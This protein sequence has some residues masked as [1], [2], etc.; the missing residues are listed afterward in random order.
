MGRKSHLKR[1]KLAE[2]RNKNRRQRRG[3]AAVARGSERSQQ[4]ALGR[5]QLDGALA[6]KRHLLERFDSFAPLRNQL[7]KISAGTNEFAGIPV[8]LPDQPMVVDPSYRFADL[9]VEMGG[10]KAAPE[11]P[12]AQSDPKIRNAWYSLREHGWIYIFNDEDGKIGHMID[13]SELNGGMLL[14]TIGASFA[15]GIEQEARAVNTLGSLVRHHTF[16]QYLLTGCFLETSKRSGVTYMFRKLRPTIAISMRPQGDHSRFPPFKTASDEENMPRVLC[17]LC[18][19]P[20]GYYDGSW[21][22]AMC[23]TDDVLAALMMMRGDE[24][25]FWSRANQHPPWA[26]QSGLGA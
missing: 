19:H 25:L 20:V 21:G 18:M 5:S 10:R 17:T 13:R 8:P 14:K 26:R 22:G 23:P 6:D 9:M 3:E 16:K 1:Q 2:S 12:R 11:I 4:K 24:R 15:W 7:R